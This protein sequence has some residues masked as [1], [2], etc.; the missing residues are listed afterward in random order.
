MISPALRKQL[1][2]VI[3]EAEGAVDDFCR[4]LDAD[5]ALLELDPEYAAELGITPERLAA[6]LARVKAL[7]LRLAELKQPALTGIIKELHRRSLVGAN[8]ARETRTLTT[9]YEPLTFV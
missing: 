3:N 5:L 1:D 4:E 2:K 6:A 7:R 8:P 9:A